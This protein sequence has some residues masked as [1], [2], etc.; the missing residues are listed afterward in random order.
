MRLFIEASSLIAAKEFELITTKWMQQQV[1]RQL[2]TFIMK[3]RNHRSDYQEFKT[4]NT[5]LSWKKELVNHMLNK[6]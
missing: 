6:V 5:L 3:Y 1:N 2:G 4:I